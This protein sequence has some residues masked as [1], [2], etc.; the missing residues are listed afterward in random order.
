LSAHQQ[1]LNLAEGDSY[2][3]DA[4]SRGLQWACHSSFECPPTGT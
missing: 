2:G 1:E 3:D 4:A